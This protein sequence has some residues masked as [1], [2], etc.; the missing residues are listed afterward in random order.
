L[1]DLAKEAQHLRAVAEEVEG[2]C[3]DLGEHVLRAV[4][5]PSD[6]LFGNGQRHRQQALRPRR[7]LAGV[8]R[9]VALRTALQHPTRKVSRPESQSPR[10]AA[11]KR[12]RRIPPSSASSTTPEPED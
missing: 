9:D 1:R 12:R 6:F 2:G 3:A 8:D 4:V 11:S 10:P 5:A 7:Q